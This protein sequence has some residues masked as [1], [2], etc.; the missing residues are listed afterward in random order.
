MGHYVQLEISLLIPEHWLNSLHECTCNNIFHLHAIHYRR[1]NVLLFILL[2]GVGR[3]VVEVLKAGAFHTHTEVWVLQTIMSRTNLLLH[4]LILKCNTASDVPQIHSSKV[5]RTSRLL[6]AQSETKEK[7]CE[8]FFFIWKQC[9]HR[10]STEEPS[11][12]FSFPP[13]N[14]PANSVW[15]Q[16]SVL[17]A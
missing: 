2:F 8:Y 17:G 4:C 12:F 9:L 5:W 6:W 1:N 14:I 7:L 11:S 16:M 10:H 15:E 13:E 3:E